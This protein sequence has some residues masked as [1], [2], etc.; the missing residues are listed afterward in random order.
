MGEGL[1]KAYSAKRFLGSV[2]LAS[3][4]LHRMI[5][6]KFAP[7]ILVYCHFNVLWAYWDS[8]LFGCTIR[9]QSVFLLEPNW[10]AKMAG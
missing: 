1:K 8:K 5:F 6:S 3:L 4:P 2:V 9:H 7:Q 10:I